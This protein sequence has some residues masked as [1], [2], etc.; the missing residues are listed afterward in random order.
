MTPERYRQ[1]GDLYH[2]ALEVDAS[3]RAAF[4]ERACAGDDD[5]RHEVE[6]L[7]ASHEQATEFI[8]APALAV[9]AGQL[10]GEHADSFAGRTFAHYRVLELLSAGGITR[11]AA[12]VGRR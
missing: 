10:A 5:L 12:A 6:S 3:E 1:V 7:I 2:A 9:A 11:Q 4:L 8:A